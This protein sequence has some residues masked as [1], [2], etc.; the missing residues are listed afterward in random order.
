M[1][2]DL[3][4]LLTPVNRLLAPLV[5][6][7]VANPLLFSPGITVL[8]VPG[9][10]S[11]IQ[12]ATPLACY[13]AGP[14]MLIGTVRGNSQWIRNLAASE[15]ARVWLWGRAREVRKLHVTDQLALLELR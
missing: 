5:Q 4:K 14:I 3:A 10:K 7:G 9:R 8:E 2:N 11:G 12:R 15:T 1:T 13:L 6:A